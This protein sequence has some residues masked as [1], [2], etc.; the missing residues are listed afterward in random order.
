MRHND[1][2]W[3]VKLAPERRALFTGGRDSKVI[4]IDPFTTKNRMILND[5]KKG[6]ACFE[7]NETKDWLITSSHD[8]FVRVYDMKT[9]KCLR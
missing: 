6:I 5:H 4:C 8:R 9:F 1:Y 3:C 7:I 2:V